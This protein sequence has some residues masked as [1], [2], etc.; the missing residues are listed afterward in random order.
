MHDCRS[1]LG[2]SG[3]LGLPAT[4]WGVVVVGQPSGG[5]VSISQQVRYAR[6]G[7]GFDVAFATYGEG[8]PLV[9]PPNILN[10]HLQMEL[11]YAATRGFYERLSERVQ[12]VRYDGRGTGMSQ[13]GIVDFSV[14]AGEQDLLAVVDRLGL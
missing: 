2:I 12:I 4:L 14:D 10:T 7:D 9:V 8:P 3:R 1:A 11:G 6:T 5:S 13:R